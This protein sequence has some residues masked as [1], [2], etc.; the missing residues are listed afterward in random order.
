MQMPL[1]IDAAEEILSRMQYNHDWCT[2]S[3]TI[4]RLAADSRISRVILS[5]TS[6]VASRCIILMRA[7]EDTPCDVPTV[8]TV[9]KL[10]DLYAW[11]EPPHATEFDLAKPP[12][13]VIL[14]KYE[15]E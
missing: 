1:S 3:G 12:K 6:T 4:S 8:E 10:L 5:H 9:L 11:H 14:F 13:T 15:E 7:G 2:I